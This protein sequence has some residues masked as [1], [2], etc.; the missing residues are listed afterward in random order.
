MMQKVTEWLTLQDE[1]QAL[2]VIP[3]HQ[4]QGIRR[5]QS[6]RIMSS[7]FVITKKTE[8]GSTKI[9]ARWCLRG[10]HDPDLIQKVLAGKCHSPTLSQLARNLL[11]QLIVSHKW[12]MKLRD[13]KGAFLEANVKEQMSE[14]PVF[15]ELPPGGVP[16]AEKG[17]LIQVTGNIYGANDAP[18]NWYV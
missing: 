8:D 15:A 2:L 17:S 14:N 3:P 12:V 4:A 9:K 5:R 11:L 13:I 10:H 6:H 7:R 1:K 18:H 16:G